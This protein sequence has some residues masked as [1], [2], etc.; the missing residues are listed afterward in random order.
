[1]KKL[2][3]FNKEQTEKRKMQTRKTQRDLQ[4]SVDGTDVRISS[5]YLEYR[6][7]MITQAQFLKEKKKLEEKR[8]QDQR[9]LKDL[10]IKYSSVDREV[11]KKPIYPNGCEMPGTDKTDSRSDTKSDRKNWGV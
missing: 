6:N 5:C 8:E 4:K 9:T 3:T 10:H 7:G 1:M 11:E 2:T